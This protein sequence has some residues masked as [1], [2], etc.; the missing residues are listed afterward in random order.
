MFGE[1]S[2]TVSNKPRGI[3]FPGPCR[4]LARPNAILN[5]YYMGVRLVIGAPLWC[6]AQKSN[7]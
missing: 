3:A 4:H 6:D 2:Y 7:K 1:R 5:A